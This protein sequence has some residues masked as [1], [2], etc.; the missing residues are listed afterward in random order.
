MWGETFLNERE[1][2]VVS[3]AAYRIACNGV[4]SRLS[5]TQ[6]QISRCS[7]AAYTSSGRVS[8]IGQ[9]SRLHRINTKLCAWMLYSFWV[10]EIKK[11]V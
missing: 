11:R 8:A 6:V 4:S 3:S 5:A 10:V 7:V 1:G 9:K 2:L